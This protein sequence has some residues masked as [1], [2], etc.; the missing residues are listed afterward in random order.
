MV[1]LAAAETKNPRQT[2]PSAVKQV[3][4]RICLVCP[5]IEC[6]GSPGD[7]FHA[8]FYL[9]SLTIVGVLVPYNNDQL[10]NGT[11]S[12]DANA[13]PFVI[14]IRNAGIK[15]LP[16]VFNVVIMIA[17]LSVGNSSIYASSRTLAALA[18]NGQAPKILGY[19]DRAGRP[20]VAIGLASLVGP[21]LK[22]AVLIVEEC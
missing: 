8:Q 10:L 6:S 16:S 4:W 9:V 22:S 5:E 7:L 13:S 14:A 3:F 18:N 1:G 11:G 21:T 15:G 19:V 17:V 2:L 20:I 12:A